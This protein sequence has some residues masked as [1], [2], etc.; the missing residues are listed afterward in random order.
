MAP[1]AKQ[2]TL[3]EN[4]IHL[5]FLRLFEE[6]I[7]IPGRGKP[8]NRKSHRQGEVLAVSKLQTS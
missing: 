7:G 8:R 1:K 2:N 3:K 5:K 6:V 4:M